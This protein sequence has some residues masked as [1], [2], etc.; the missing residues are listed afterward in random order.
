MQG[1]GYILTGVLVLALVG[2]AAFYYSTNASPLIDRRI[3]SVSSCMHIDGYVTI[4]ADSRGFNE[5]VSHG[6]PETPWPLIHVN[7]GDTVHLLLCNLDAVEAHGFAID[8]YFDVGVVLGPGKDY[9]LTFT[10][11]QTGSFRMFCDVFCTVH[12]YMIGSLIVS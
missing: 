12:P 4:I 8:H 10:A 1:R 6:A 9:Q 2:G 7:R 11:T 3:S 5:S